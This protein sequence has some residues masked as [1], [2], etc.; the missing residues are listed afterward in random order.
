MNEYL[1]IAG[2]TEF[3]KILS[4]VFPSYFL[5]FCM[6]DK[7]ATFKSIGVLC[8]RDLIKEYE[9]LLFQENSAESR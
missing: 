1:I 2:N 6:A 4:S 5:G 9:K 7:V 3:Y 8:Q